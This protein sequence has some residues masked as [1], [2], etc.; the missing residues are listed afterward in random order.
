MIRLKTLSVL[1]GVLFT[2][3]ISATPASAIFV[4][5]N[6]STQGV[7]HA[8]KSGEFKY[9]NQGTVTCEAKTIEG[10]WQIQTAGQIKEHQVNG[11]QEIAKEGPHL[12]I[13]IKNWGTCTA[14]IGAGE[15]LPAKVKPCELQLVQSEKGSLSATGGVVTPC[16]IKV[17][18]EK[19]TC[20]IQVPAGMEK[21]P[22]S[23][24]G[25]NVGLKSNVLENI[26]GVGLK[27]KSAINAGG[28]GQLAGE[29]IYAESLSG[30]SLCTLKPVTEEA[31]L[32]G[33]E[34]E[35]VGVEA[36]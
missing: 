5:T 19:P 11:K 31:T 14:K 6:G 1:V 7:G 21:S 4:S 34:V 27:G 22:E 9:A 25:I 18:P 2:L 8:L 24:V 35:A 33:L 20:E 26:K 3:A 16:L 12:N 10:K 28:Q 13:Q 32:E 17:G 30:H 36:L 15:S 29:G 23:G